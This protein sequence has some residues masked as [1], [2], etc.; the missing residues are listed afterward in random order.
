[1]VFDAATILRKGEGAPCREFE[2]KLQN[3]LMFSSEREHLFP[4][5]LGREPITSSATFAGVNFSSKSSSKVIPIAIRFI[6]LV[7]LDFL[8]TV[9]FCCLGAYCRRQPP[10]RKPIMKIISFERR[11]GHP[12]YAIAYR[13]DRKNGQPEPVF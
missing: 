10:I 8:A 11:Q 9:H 2:Q 4:T 6:L 5:L 7:W 3:V 13:A 12:R 1:M